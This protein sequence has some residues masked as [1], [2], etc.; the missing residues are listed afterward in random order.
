MSDSKAQMLWAPLAWLNNA[1][2]GA[3]ARDV[4]LEIDA[5]G[6]WTA[7][8]PGLN[9]E[10]ASSA[11]ARILT[12][13]LLPGLVNAHSHAFQRAFAGLAERRESEHDDF[14]SWRDRMYRVAL[15]ISPEQLKA[16]A[17]QLYVELL[18][19]GYTHV[20]EFHYL[21][22]APDGRAYDD[23]LTMTWMLIE[24]ARESGIGLTVLPVLYER[25]GFS[26]PALRDDQRRFA[27]DA[28]WVVA[29][30][31]RIN[32]STS[33]SL[34]NSGVAIHSLR[35]AHPESITHL[36]G[37]A[38]G[39]IHIHVAEQT[40]EVD[41]CIKTT[42]LRPVE[43]LL[44]NHVLDSRWQLIH[45]THVTQ[46]EIEGVAMSG[47][48][49]VI[50]PTTE[51]NLGDGTTDIAAWLNAGT[52]MSIGSDSHVTRD[53]REELRLMEYGQR[54]QHRSRNISASPLTGPTATAERL[55][56]RVT[57][58]GAAAAGHTRWGLMVGARADALMV[59]PEEPALLG[60]PPSRTLDAMVFSSPA[61]P[62]ANV[63][64]AGR[65]VVRDAAHPAQK[66][67]AN[68]FADAM[69]VIWS[70]GA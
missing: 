42:G 14:W 27:T 36:V 7:I 49:A 10:Q 31:K 8:T 33:G 25:A 60:V 46:S 5:S 16:V 62:F 56:S 43:W 13:P 58:G 39:P 40:G 59:D 38:Q 52:A 45:A 18:R 35:A 19:G 17:T 29:A 63:M 57:T 6:H 69:R 55:F 66:S 28:A 9:S 22:H 3:W 68:A 65:W 50:C 1:T 12:G 47:A 32:E 24:A 37:N 41:E 2:G 51:A 67:A 21:H 26:A 70:D 64:V 54:L 34:V 44:R 61:Q 30:Q 53:W 11:N 23:P 4:L 48:A 15:V 20:C